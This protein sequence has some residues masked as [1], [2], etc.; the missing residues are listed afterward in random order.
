MNTLEKIKSQIE[1]INKKKEEMVEELRKDFPEI[2]KPVFEEC[3]IIQSF[4]WNQY[5]PYFNDGDACEFS[6]NLDYPDIN[7]INW[8]DFSSSE[9]GYDGYEFIAKSYHTDMDKYNELIQK[10]PENTPS[11]KLIKLAGEVLKFQDALSSIPDE[12]FLDLFGDHVSVT[13]DK[14]GNVTTNEY[15]HD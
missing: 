4:S 1:E 5:T 10:Y 8:D 13:I 7:G 6:V 3:E 14:E 9:Q 11:D 15:D 12:F 2:L